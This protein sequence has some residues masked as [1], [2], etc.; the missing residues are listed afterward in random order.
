MDDMHGGSCIVEVGQSG[1]EGRSIGVE[2]RI[3]SADKVE[4]DVEL[5]LCHG[6]IPAQYR[7]RLT[8]TKSRTETIVTHIHYSS[9]FIFEPSLSFVLS[10]KI[11]AINNSVP[12][13]TDNGATPAVTRTD[14]IASLTTTEP[15]SDALRANLLD[16]PDVD[17]GAFFGDTSPALAISQAPATSGPH[18]SMVPT[19]AARQP[20]KGKARERNASPGLSTPPLNAAAKD[21]I[22]NINLGD[23]PP[24][25]K[26]YDGKAEGHALQRDLHSLSQNT[27]QLYAEFKG[28]Q[29]DQVEMASSFQNQLPE[30][31]PTVAEVRERNSRTI[32]APWSVLSQLQERDSVAASAAPPS[33]PPFIVPPPIV[34]SIDHTIAPLL[35][36]L[37]PASSPV[38]AT[39]DMAAVVPR[40]RP[41]LPF[42]MAV[43]PESD[44]LIGEEADHPLSPLQL[45]AD[46]DD[47]GS[48][49]WS[50]LQSNHADNI[51]GEAGTRGSS[52]DSDA[53][54]TFYQRDYLCDHASSDPDTASN[55]LQIMVAD[56]LSSL[57]TLSVTSFGIEGQ[58]VAEF[59]RVS[60][61]GAGEDGA[62]LPEVNAKVFG[63]KKP[64]GD[65][66]ELLESE[67]KPKCLLD[68]N[69]GELTMSC[70]SK[71]GTGAGTSRNVFGPRRTASSTEISGSQDGAEAD[72]GGLVLYLTSEN[73]STKL[74]PSSGAMVDFRVVFFVFLAAESSMVT[75]SV[76]ASALRLGRDGA[77]D[78]LQTGASGGTLLREF[79]APLRV[80]AA[81]AMR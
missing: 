51:E 71:C 39:P 62:D 40:P 8:R 48:D 64:L 60:E 5:M 7:R 32:G 23:I 59:G 36:P 49:Q 27:A 66:F 79:D 81:G 35:Y 14:T 73:G 30:F 9:A 10:P 19:S 17:L 26:H 12:T 68:E 44:A 57:E 3:G 75:G 70:S 34:P 46:P 42:D 21:F 24:H 52:S 74:S 54:W 47:S 67:K 43:D 13:P 69:K 80:P 77:V 61:G 15:V 41:A 25:D 37:H 33:P 1:I 11:S 72:S 18:V 2:W 16:G 31:D 20:A 4:I 22:D 28:S 58:F 53:D 63:A 76:S 56:R 38:P 6:A 65:G 45:Y 50:D 78:G 55:D 29:V